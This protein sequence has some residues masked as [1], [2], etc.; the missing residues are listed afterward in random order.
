[1]GLDWKKRKNT[2]NTGI[3]KLRCEMMNKMKELR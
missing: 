2:E 1:M 3:S